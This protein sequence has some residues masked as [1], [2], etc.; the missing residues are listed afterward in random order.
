ML[1]PGEGKQYSELFKKHVVKN[2]ETGNK[3]RI[4]A[5]SVNKILR[6]AEDL[7]VSMLY[8]IW[9]RVIEE[10]L[11]DG[12]P[13]KYLKESQFYMACKLVALYQKHYNELMTCSQYGKT[14]NDVLPPEKI[15]E[16]I[17]KAFQFYAKFDMDKFDQ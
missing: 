2:E 5:D 8:A 12:Q 14:I 16:Y 4:P 7:E 3:K 6:C 13:T 17:Q 11:A 15:N 9:E 1:S 10:N